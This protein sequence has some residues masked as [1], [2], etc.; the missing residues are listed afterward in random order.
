MKETI[1]HCDI[2][3]MAHDGK[4][5]L[6]SVSVVFTTEQNEGRGTKPYLEVK[7]IDICASCLKFMTENYR[8]VMAQGAMGYNK[9]FL[10]PELPIS[11]KHTQGTS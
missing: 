1:T 3:D 9:Y 7:D 8:A 11:E 10:L 5:A 4:V 6:H 2:E